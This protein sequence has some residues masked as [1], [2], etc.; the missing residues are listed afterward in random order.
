[1]NYNQQTSTTTTICL[2]ESTSGAFC[3]EAQ[4]ETIITYN[5]F[6]GLLLGVVVG[7]VIFFVKIFSK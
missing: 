7:S 1:M 2:T 5:W 3:A 4:T 6:D